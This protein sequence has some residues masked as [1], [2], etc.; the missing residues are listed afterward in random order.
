MVHYMVHYT[1]QQACHMAAE[2]GA[3]EVVRPLVAAEADCTIMAES[4]ITPLIVAA[5]AGEE[6]MVRLADLIVTN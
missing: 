1:L 6:E 5:A 2:I 4:A 3:V